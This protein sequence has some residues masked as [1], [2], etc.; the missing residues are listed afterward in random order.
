[1]TK[2][3]ISFDADNFNTDE[4]KVLLL[5]L[6]N[7]DLDVIKIST[8]LPG[9]FTTDPKEIT[10]ALQLKLL[11]YSEAKEIVLAGISSIPVELIEAA[12][13]K[14][15]P[16]HITSPL[17][18]ENDGTMISGRAETDSPC[19]KAI[20]VKENTT[21]VSL[22][23]SG[24]WHQVGFLADV[25]SIIRDLGLSVDQVST[26]ER[27]V[28]LTLDQVES[29][30]DPIR[31]NELEIKLKSFG[32]VSIQ[33]DKAT[34]SL[35]GNRIKGALHKIAPIFEL[36]IEQKIY[37]ISHSSSDINLGIVVDAKQAKRLLK[38]LHQ[39]LFCGDHF[40]PIFGVSLNELES[41]EPEDDGSYDF[42]W[43][44]KKDQLL[45]IA[46][47]SKNA[48]YVYD[49]DT[50]RQRAKGLKQLSHLSNILFAVKANNNPDILK[51]IENEGYGF[52]CVSIQEV[53]HILKHFPEINTKRILF[54]PNFSPREEY[55]KAFE[56]GVNVTLD[57][58]YP[59][60][61]WPETF[62]KR[63]YFVRID[64][65]I[66]KGH[67]QYVHTAGN[68]SKFGVPPHELEKLILLTEETAS[69]IVGLH[70][71]SGSGIL[72]SNAWSKVAEYLFSV[73][74]KFPDVKVIDLGGGLGIPEKI[75]QN[76]LDLTQVN[77]SL[78]SFVEEFPNLEL[79]MEPGRYFVAESGVLLS[80]VTQVKKKGNIH[81]V[82]T[83]AGMNSLIR[84]A[85]YGSHHEIKNL[86]RLE[87]NN[88]LVANVVGPICESGDVL[89]YGRKL[90]VSTSCGDVLLIGTAGAY[91]QV[92]GSN[93]TMRPTAVEIVLKEEK[94]Y[95]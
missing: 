48:C 16:I 64:T 25:F 23:T 84:P 42:W 60:E 4:F 5:Q 59:L 6:E 86:S 30:V 55:Q 62:F 82:G 1:M 7:G 32:D 21:I 76:R 26:S 54:T 81:Y 2:T 74:P 37:M 10:D 75:G 57:S 45:E 12:S 68:E 15:I 92:M 67:H 49:L 47:K 27:N 58:T 13:K 85:L 14:S 35:I 36:F 78:T 52:E 87:D 80:K 83:N 79:W 61:T 56:Y 24:M 9:L 29:S 20:A 65:G 71:H 17:Y 51:I 73:L 8:S 46:E 95:G 66:G 50:V 43:I 69:K 72:T 90:P 33:T 40:N 38:K 39:N 11:D 19:V 28:T 44:N 53:E 88:T 3:I 94:Y 89:G 70:A 93:Y 91:G 63:E 41:S 18:P 22:T 34:L 77:D 31:L